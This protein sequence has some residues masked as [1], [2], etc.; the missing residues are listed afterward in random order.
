MELSVG[1]IFELPADNSGMEDFKTL[2]ESGT[3]RI[4]R[5]KGVHPYRSP[6]EWYDQETD[7]WV[8]LLQ[9]NATLEIRDE[10]IIDMK[11]GD[12]VFLPAHK[13]HRVNT[14]SESPPCIWLA[15][16]GKMK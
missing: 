12:F 3:V 16:H 6:G 10:K 11:T 5:I 2:F 1:N 13:I 8:I 14:T 4:E 9:G 7:E 15:I